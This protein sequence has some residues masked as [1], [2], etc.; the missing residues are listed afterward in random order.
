[1]HKNGIGS[2]QIYGENYREKRNA[3]LTAG[4]ICVILLTL[5][6]ADFLREDR[7]FS[8]QENRVLAAK[9]ELTRERVL[10]GSFMKDYET[11]VIQ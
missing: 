7:L 1:M 2:N 9:P 11:Y 6:V 10:D 5:T 8:P 4:V 3:A